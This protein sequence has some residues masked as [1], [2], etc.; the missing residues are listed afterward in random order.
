MLMQ[1]LQS[2]FFAWVSLWI[3]NLEDDSLCLRVSI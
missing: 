1:F 3:V 2:E